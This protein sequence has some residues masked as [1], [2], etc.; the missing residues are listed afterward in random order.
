MPLLLILGAVLC[1]LPVLAV[2]LG[3]CRLDRHLAGFTHTDL[4]VL[5]AGAVLLVT[6]YAT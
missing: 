1:G 6:W 2:L 5:A 4:A 3:L